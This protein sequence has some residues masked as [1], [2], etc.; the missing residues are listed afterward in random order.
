MDPKEL[1]EIIA[2]I[3]G[4]NDTANF[5]SE[6]KESA[7]ASIRVLYESKKLFDLLSDSD[8]T[9]D[10]V[11]FQISA[12]NKAAVQYRAKTGINWLF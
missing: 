2:F 8:S 6:N 4:E 3:R 5:L 9:L 10:E 7:A 12:K 1:L 11:V